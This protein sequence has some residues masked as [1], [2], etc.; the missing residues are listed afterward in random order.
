MPKMF[1]LIRSDSFETHI[2]LL[3]ATTTDFFQSIV[4]VAPIH[5]ATEPESFSVKYRQTFAFFTFSIL[6]GASC[7][8]TTTPILT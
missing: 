2:S 4:H 1:D 8:L 6:N 5:Q 3:I 7:T